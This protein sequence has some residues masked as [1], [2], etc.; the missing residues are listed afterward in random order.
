MDEC[1]Y[2]LRTAFDW[3][4]VLKSGR[5]VLY[6]FQ[7]VR[8]FHFILCSIFSAHFF[9]L[10]KFVE[11]FQC[12]AR[13]FLD[14]S[15]LGSQIIK[16]NYPTNESLPQKIPFVWY[17]FFCHFSESCVKG[18][19]PRKSTRNLCKIFVQGKGGAKK[20]LTIHIRFLGK[21]PQ[22]IIFVSAVFV[23]G[24]LLNLTLFTS[25]VFSD[26]FSFSLAQTTPKGYWNQFFLE[27]I[28]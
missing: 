27:D 2:I 21:H 25:Q 12:C 4:A 3:L 22:L 23:S 14:R 6:P 17:N 8:T 11:R 18:Y 16:H 9:P 20:L 13:L 10:F 26:H 19:I 7:F 24:V 1:P 15:L 28:K 5:R